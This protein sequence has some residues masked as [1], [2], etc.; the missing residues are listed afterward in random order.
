MSIAPSS[1]VERSPRAKPRPAA[2]TVAA[3]AAS[4]PAADIP[5]FRPRAC[6]RCS[7]SKLKCNWVS[8]P[9][10]A[11][12]ERCA[13]SKTQ[14]VLPS[15]KPRGPRRG[16]PTRVGQL[17]QKI[18]GIM[19]LL[20]ASQ[21]IQKGSS[22]SAQPQ[23][24][25]PS[26]PSDDPDVRDPHI[27][28]PALSSPHSP[29]SS[30]P[31]YDSTA[32]QPLTPSTPAAS[33]TT[34]SMSRDSMSAI[35]AGGPQSTPSCS[36]Q[37]HLLQQQQRQLQQQQQ[38]QQ[39]QQ[40]LP[41]A[42]LVRVPPLEHV[43]IVPGLKIT[44]HDAEIALAD[45]RRLYSP[46]F[47]FVPLAYNVPAHELYHTQ[48]LLFRILVQVVLPQSPQMQRDTRRWIRE[49]LAHHIVVQ[50][51]KHIGLLQAILVH[52]GWIDL[53]YY[54]EPNT[55]PVLQLAI[56]LVVDLGLQRAPTMM[57]LMPANFVNDA[58]N[59]LKGKSFGPKEHSL[60]EMLLFRRTQALPFSTY[61]D[62]CC[63]VL[64]DA[65][66]HESDAFLVVIVRLQQIA[67]RIYVVL[68]NPDSDPRLAS[69]GCAAMFMSIAVLRRDLDALI[70]SQPM[71]VKNNFFLRTN[72]HAIVS[73]LYE[74]AIYMRASGRTPANTI[75]P[76]DAA[77]RTACLWNCLQALRDFFE[78]QAS[79][80]IDILGRLPFSAAT[81]LA[82]AVA[83]SM[84]LLFL[85]DDPD[86]DVVRARRS[87]DFVAITLRL[88][89]HFQA[90]EDFE[91]AP[92]NTQ[93]LGRK[94]R[95]LSDDNRAV[96]AIF[97]DKMRWIRLWYASRLPME[98]RGMTDA[99]A[100]STA[101]GTATPM[102]AAGTSDV[103]GVP[104]LL[105]MPSFLPPRPHTGQQ[106]GSFM[107][108]DGLGAVSSSDEYDLMF[109][110]SIFTHLDPLWLIMAT[111]LNWYH[112][113]QN[114]STLESSG[115]PPVCSK[116]C[117]SAVGE[118]VLRLEN[119]SGG[120]GSD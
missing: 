44:F 19:S 36:H 52:L 25:A 74:P 21:Q 14:C 111:L 88:E 73:R 104:S 18:D 117:R 75:D 57:R 50:E 59:T 22:P 115:V 89:E 94:K 28:G 58:V 76:A 23:P 81:H 108:V 13:K 82:F 33:A 10:E 29:E 116:L 100:T 20:T 24:R 92:A 37:Q 1:S 54:M 46:Y 42:S 51:E 5:R 80:P 7:T 32:T 71:E 85:L 47:P 101:T 97:R 17:E 118:I 119:G 87:L 86:W 11:P 12:C 83:T 98:Q 72:Y 6:A 67:H 96:L 41:P 56:G 90:A 61:L 120:S 106:Q 48:P 9:G 77:E 26:T 39:Q 114:S 107:D 91:D 112:I 109:W 79:I 45:Y 103:A 38:Q 93:G 84:R 40:P 113:P 60:D 53:A 8:E 66:E 102:S 49:Q 99:A 15:L 68:P 70:H 31:Q 35:T 55:T 2:M 62:H 43:E 34:P 110:Q 4:T 27:V 78:A 69:G 64:L 65:H 63:R 3:S 105:P 95:Y 16:N 30:L